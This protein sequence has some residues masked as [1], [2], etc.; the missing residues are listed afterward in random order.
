MENDQWITIVS[1]GLRHDRESHIGID[2]SD[3]IKGDLLTSDRR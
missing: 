1:E 2:F 3:S